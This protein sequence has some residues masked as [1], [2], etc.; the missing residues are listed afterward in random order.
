M[1][2]AVDRIHDIHVDPELEPPL[3]DDENDDDDHPLDRQP[4]VKPP[5]DLFWLPTIV[6]ANIRIVVSVRE[7]TPAHE[8]L[9]ERKLSKPKLCACRGCTKNTQCV[10]HHTQ[11]TTRNMS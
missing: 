11:L 3:D 4:Q 2:D 8:Q 7:G 6:P 5:H 9:L 1:I 10:A